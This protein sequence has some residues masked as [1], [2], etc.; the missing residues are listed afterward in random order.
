MGTTLTVGTLV[1]GD[2][3]LVGHVGDSRGSSSTTASCAR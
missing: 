3:L 1:A 2:T